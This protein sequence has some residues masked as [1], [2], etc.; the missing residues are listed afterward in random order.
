MIHPRSRALW[1]CPRCGERFTTA[2]QW[3]SCGKFALDPLFQGSEPHV[4]RL[5]DRFVSIARE[6]GPLTV[7]PQKSRIALQ[8]RMRFAALVPRKTALSGHLV[9]AR[10]CESPRFRKVET[11]SP[12]SH[13]HLFRL[14]A[15][16]QFDPEL[17]SLIAEAYE[18]GCQRHWEP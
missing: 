6:N 3:H 15:E 5:F 14:D 17:R 13:A 12:R 4:R 16:D 10:R 9:L 2:N 11:Y 1:K 8:V 18:V 7:I